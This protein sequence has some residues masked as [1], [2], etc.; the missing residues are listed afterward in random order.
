M[1][2]TD[3][4]EYEVVGSRRREDTRR[5]NNRYEQWCVRK[6]QNVESRPDETPSPHFAPMRNPLAIWKAT[7][8]VYD[9]S[10]THRKLVLS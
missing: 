7:L 5:A 2:E 8:L 1:I 10:H 3:R 6:R 9:G 4:D